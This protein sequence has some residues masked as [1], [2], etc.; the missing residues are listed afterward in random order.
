MNLRKTP[1]A[2]APAAPVAAEDAAPPAGGTKGRPTPKRR[3]ATGSRG[4]VTAPKTRKEAIARQREL[5]KQAKVNART[6]RTARTSTAMTAAQRREAIKRGDP[7]FLPRRD[8]GKTRGLARDYVDSHRM[9]SNYMLWLFPVMIAGALIPVLSLITLVI[10]VVLLLEWYIIGK[11]I[12]ALAIERFG[13]AEGGAMTLGFYAGRRAYLPRKWRLP[14]PR[15]ERGD[16][17]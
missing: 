10:F 5:A 17:I 12:R 6:A 2:E 13:K 3:D 9:V 14:A 1:A 8:K 16:A 11:R 15:V 4:P 7:D